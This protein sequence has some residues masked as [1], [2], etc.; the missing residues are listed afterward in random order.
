MGRGH[1][2]PDRDPGTRA[3]GMRVHRVLRAFLG[4]LI[5]AIVCLP[6]SPSAAIISSPI[7][8][9]GD[10]ADWTGVRADQ[11]NSS[12][13]TQITDPDPDYP[14]QPDRDVY[15]VNA[16]WDDEYLYLAYRR[17]SGGTKAVTF[18]AYIDRGG[19]GLLQNTDAVV[20]WSVGQSDSSRFADAHAPSPTAGIYNYNQAIIGKDGPYLHPAGDPMGHDG[21]TPDG[22]ADVQS[23]QTLPQDPMD[24]WMASNGVEFEGR[25]AWS[26]LGLAP[27][28]PIAIH[29][30]N[31][32]GSSFG[33]KWVPSNTRKWIGQPPQYLE[34]NRG[35][36]E[37]NV[38][39]IWWLVA[40]G[41]SI[42]PDRQGGGEAGSTVTYL[43][44]V[45]N[46]SNQQ[47]TIDL[48][49]ISNRGWSVWFTDLAGNPL[50]SDAVTLDRGDST[51][52]QVH[53][54]I[55]EGTPQG[56]DDLTSMT[57]A[58]RRDPTVKD[59]ATDTTT[60]GRVV[61]LPDQSATMAPGQTAAYT[62]T[63]Q[64][65][66]DAAETFDLSVL[67]SLGFP[68]TITDLNGN[69]ITTIDIGANSSAE[70]RVNVSVP[71]VAL[72]GLQDVA[73]LTATVQGAPALRASATATTRVA[74]GLAITP[75]N[76]GFGGAGSTMVYSH[77]VTNSWPTTRTITLTGLSS[78]GWPV[79][80]FDSDGVTPVTSITLGPN[81]ESRDIVVR[82][83]VPVGTAANT[84]DVTT[85]RATTGA[86][87]VTAIDTTT[88]RTL[89]LFDSE[90]YTATEDRFEL[91]E[92]GF[93]RGTGLSA[94]S[95]V[96]FVWKDSNGTVVR[97][98]P[99]RIVDT[100]GMAFDAYDT[101]MTD[102]TGNW[103]VELW[104]RAGG[105]K[106]TLLETN[107]F[108]VSWNA[109]ITGLSAT[110]AP[111]VGSDVAVTSSA[112][113]DNTRTLANTTMTY[114]I[115]WDDNGDG[116]FNS[117]DTWIDSAGLPHTWDG[118]A[119]VSSHVTTGIDVAGG[120]SWS[121]STPWTV[122]NR[123]FPH[124]GDYNVTA[125]WTEPNGRVIDVKTTQFY[126]IP[127]L[128]WPVFVLGLLFVGIVMGRR[129][130]PALA[131]AGDRR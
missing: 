85:I 53:V 31:A 103:T 95:S 58:S 34:E 40:R 98:S 51:T 116:A 79:S 20:W 86:T 125:T 3:R 59:T 108:T 88:V 17:T 83:A 72:I 1:D 14:G 89:Q 52:V 109:E 62:F 30:V 105:N 43:H 65:N 28:S 126:S 110:D 49:A 41:L 118:V 25:V 47:D 87:T 32:N 46:E 33:T 61:V 99:D 90:G 4:A 117:G 44:T 69:S 128:G 92:T 15:L 63:V 48:S 18:A 13:D 112:V 73:R 123:D 91:G 39:D 22:W 12:H 29:F 70:V 19:D 38:D 77:T 101:K 122:N 35:Q 56:V 121:E 36:I 7:N 115:W 45:T 24:G 76:T 102:L 21:E 2:T 5:F 26:D 97:T 96:F 80:V 81:G 11:D 129:L 50:A 74:A 84:V 107:P 106:L 119:S 60:C 82:V 114:V 67:T 113:N 120:A 9:D 55:P 130:A 71:A 75:S 10:L 64:N 94:G 131:E 54:A 100:T 111:G 42:S 6:A 124:Q 27:G 37:D 104:S 127:A 57:A 68:Y 66:T 8:I 16:T 23:G 78:R 93:A